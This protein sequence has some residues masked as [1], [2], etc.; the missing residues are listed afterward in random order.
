MIQLTGDLDWTSTAALHEEL[1]VGRRETTVRERTLDRHWWLPRGP[2]R[3]FAGHLLRRLVPAPI[4]RSCGQ[5]GGKTSSR[6][7]LDLGSTPRTKTLPLILGRWP[8]MV[9]LMLVGICWTGQ[10]RSTSIASSSA[11]ITFSPVPTARPCD[12]QRSSDAGRPLPRGAA[13]TPLTA[14]VPGGTIEF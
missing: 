11:W 4:E 14:E 9:S 2:T 1:A 12:E 6:P 5:V 8:G 10:M 3:N 7:P 13:G